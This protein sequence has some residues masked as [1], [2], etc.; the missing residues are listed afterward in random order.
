MNNRAKIILN[1][2]FVE[3]TSEEK[4]S[5]NEKFDKKIKDLFYD[6][7]Q[8]AIINKYDYWQENPEGCL[9]LIILLDQFS[10]NLFR[11]NPKA[12]A[13][14]HKAK[15]I[16]TK[17]VNKGFHKLL[18]FNQILFLFLP[19]MHSENL[20]D[21]LKCINLIDEYLKDSP[22]Y[23]EIIKFA[24][25]HLEIIKKFKRFPYRNKVLNRQNTEEENNYLNST[26][27]GFFNI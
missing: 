18:N 17:A 1:F 6:D 23:N 26:H 15:K 25:I 3:S 21:Q 10:R 2:W 13:M 19:L 5:R 16:A 9:A 27:H 14:D 4:F 20:K 12:F 11:N 7:Y 22:K 24:K 8:N